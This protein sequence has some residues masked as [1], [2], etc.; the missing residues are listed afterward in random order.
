MD[1]TRRAA[2][3][4]AIAELKRGEGVPPEEHYGLLREGMFSEG[5]KVEI[6]EEAACFLDYLLYGLRDD[7][8]PWLGETIANAWFQRRLHNASRADEM[9]R[10]FVAA[11]DFDHWTALNLIAARLHRERQP[12]PDPLADWAAE[13]HE[14]N[15]TP[16]PKERGHGGRPPYALQDRNRIFNMANEWLKYY[17]MTR[18]DDRISAISAYAGDDELVVRKGL[19]R[20]RDTKWRRAPWLRG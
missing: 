6:Q 11:D 10:E 2:W 8:L 19:T 12:F 18:L 14:G 7:P 16:P 1:E 4:A 5:N 20:W 13:K 3:K 17:G 15:P 9:L